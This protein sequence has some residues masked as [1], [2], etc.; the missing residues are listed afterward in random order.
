MKEL[1]PEEAFALAA[2]HGDWS[3]RLGRYLERTLGPGVAK[4]MLEL[5]QDL[6]DLQGL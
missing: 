1:T 5:D 4:H 6:R 2:D 3:H